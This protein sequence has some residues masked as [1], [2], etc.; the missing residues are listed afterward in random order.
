MSH[1]FLLTDICVC[2]CQGDSADV[3]EKE[4]K[5]MGKE[6]DSRFGLAVVE[7]GIV[8]RVPA[9]YSENQQMW[10]ISLIFHSSASIIKY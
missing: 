3:S 8:T 4:M 5:H 7:S 1:T 6:E 2:A 9:L 10:L